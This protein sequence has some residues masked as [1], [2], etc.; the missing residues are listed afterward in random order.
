V[1]AEVEGQ[2]LSDCLTKVVVF[3][4]NATNDVAVS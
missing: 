1:E 4:P 2:S 3:F